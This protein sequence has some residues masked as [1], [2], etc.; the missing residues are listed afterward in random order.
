MLQKSRKCAITSSYTVLRNSDYKVS[1]VVTSDY[2][3]QWDY[4]ISMNNFKQDDAFYYQTGQITDFH[5]FNRLLISFKSIS[6]LLASWLV[7]MTSSTAYTAPHFVVSFLL[8]PLVCK[9]SSIIPR[10][11]VKQTS[12]RCHGNVFNIHVHNVCSNCFI[13]AWR[14]LHACLMFASLCKWF[15]SNQFQN[16]KR[17]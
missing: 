13:F 7:H 11:H 16:K 14:L 1:Y 17:K 2:Q 8:C 10:L 9:F 12:S 6:L 3:Q 5:H 4:V 15:I